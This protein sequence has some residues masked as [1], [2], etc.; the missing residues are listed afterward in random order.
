MYQ[1]VRFAIDERGFVRCVSAE[2]FVLS[3][4]AARHAAGL[5]LVFIGAIFFVCLTRTSP[6]L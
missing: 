1:V 4:F 2:F 3:F 6:V 5:N